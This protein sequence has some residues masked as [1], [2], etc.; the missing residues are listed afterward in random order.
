MLGGESR[1]YIESAPWVILAP[2]AFL[3]TVVYA[4]N[5]LGDSLRTCW[6]PITRFVGRQ[7]TVLVRGVIDG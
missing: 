1:L 5:L 3:T 6:T 7:A 4:F 2:A